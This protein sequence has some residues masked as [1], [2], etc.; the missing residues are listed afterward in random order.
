M[1]YLKSKSNLM[2]VCR[3]A[4]LENE[5]KNQ[6]VGC[7]AY[8]VDTVG[9]YEGV[10]KAYIRNQLQDDIIENPINMIKFIDPIAGEPV[11][12]G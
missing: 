5:Y 8:Y 3:H 2:I 7:R 6:Y 4:N 1:G 9:K 11:N 10:I 12:K